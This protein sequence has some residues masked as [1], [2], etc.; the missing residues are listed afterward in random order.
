MEITVKRFK[1]PEN[2]F[3]SLFLEIIL[4]KSFVIDCKTFFVLEI[5]RRC[6]AYNKASHKS[7]GSSNRFFVTLLRE[8]I[9]L[10]ILK[11]ACER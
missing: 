3:F 4:R 8:H 9:L 6:Q 1:E 5:D 7:A 10:A 2:Y 11:A